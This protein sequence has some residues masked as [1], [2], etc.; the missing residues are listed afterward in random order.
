MSLRAR[1][2]LLEFRHFEDCV[3]GLLLGWIDE[4]AGV[5]HQDFGVLRIVREL[6]A[7]FHKLAHHDLGVDEVF[8]TA[9]TY[10]ANFQ[11]DWS[12]RLRNP[13]IA[14][15]RGANAHV[16]SAETLQRPRRKP[17]EIKGAAAGPSE[18]RLRGL[19]PSYSYLSATIGSTRAALL[20]GR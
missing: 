2:D 7:A 4:A 13:R 6:V 16:C 3:D 15:M 10:K 20:A 9:E 19:V 12:G 18:T 5:D 14:G 8:G 11:G 1:P 17:L